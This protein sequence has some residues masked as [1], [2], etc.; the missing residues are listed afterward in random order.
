MYSLQM[1]Y[2]DF[3]KTKIVSRSRQLCCS[4]ATVDKRTL[5]LFKKARYWQQ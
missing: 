5:I 3:T 2:P 1:L 4:F